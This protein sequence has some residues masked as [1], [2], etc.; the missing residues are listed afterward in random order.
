MPQAPGEAV[1]KVC[2]HCS[3]LSFTGAPHCPWCG[4]G[5]T[6]RLW[7][8][9]LLT[10]LITAALTLGGTTLLLIRTGEELDAALDDE[11]TRVERDLDRNFDD[12]RQS[13]R[14]EL[15]ARLPPAPSAP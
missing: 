6:R 4:G 3:T 13:V 7:P 14:E 5:F 8:A 9:L 12:I 10:G 2:P 15:D 1:Q 11:V